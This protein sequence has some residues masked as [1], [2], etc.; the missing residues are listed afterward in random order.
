MT[1]T[2]A[3]VAGQAPLG[4]P[5]PPRTLWSKW[6]PALA[7][8]GPAFILLAVWYV[9]PTIA[10]VIRS[11]FSDS[12]NDFVGFDNYHKIFTDDILITA[13]K[14]NAIWV[15]VVP[16]T[17]TALGV[18]FAVLTERIGWAIAFKFAVFAPLAISLFAAGIIWRATMYDKDPSVGSINHVVGIVK[19]TF[20][21]SGILTRANASSPDLTGSD[22]AGFTLD[23]TLQPGDTA[24][25]GLTAIPPGDMPGNAEQAV[26]PQTA[27]GGISGVVWRDF[28]PGGGGEAGVVEQGELGIP[29]ATV[30]LLD[31]SGKKV[32]SATTDADGSFTFPG[33][34]PGSYRVAVAKTTF[35]APFT[36]VSWLGP[37]LITPAIIIAYIWTAAGF[38]MVVIGAGLAAIP[39]DVLEAARTD[40]GTEFQVF[41]RVTVPLLSPVLGVVFITQVIGVL[42]VFDIVLAISPGSTLNDATVVALEMWRKSFSGQNQFGVGAALAV[43]LF[44]LVIPVLLL[45][46]R[47]FRRENVGS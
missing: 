42:K 12:G 40:G 3:S 23:K 37:K 44:V 38:A 18:M 41:R 29:G 34:G 28:K 21:A 25:L 35:A 6:G 4:G 8:V 45:N 16:A 43:F 14:N 46:I 26:G 15:A 1:S 24:L 22:K 47:R 39:R 36:G 30:N 17:V 10:T 31:D 7:F 5:P 19:G 20:T 33:L 13:I 9:Y 2:S 11:L 27:Q 32:N